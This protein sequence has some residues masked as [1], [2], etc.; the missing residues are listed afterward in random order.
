MNNNSRLKKVHISYKHDVAHKDAINA[1]LEGLKRNEIPVSYDEIDLRY[2]CDIDKYEKEIGESDRVIIFVTDDYLK[3]IECMFEMSQMF[4]NKNV[5][6]RIFPIVDLQKISRDGN[7]LA[8][9]KNYWQK[10]KEKKLNLAIPEYG[11]ST[12]LLTEAFKIS[13][14]LETLDDF[15]NFICRHYTGE[16]KKLIKDDAALL[17]DEL[18][19]TMA[20]VLIDNEV[21]NGTSKEEQTDCSREI[22]QNGEKSIYIENNQGNIT[23]N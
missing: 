19:K 1:I 23:I 16:Y 17:I 6:E 18:K 7:G 8:E 13:G 5:M 2:K 4:K 11:S 9:V 12:F 3:S 21:K 10:E 15:W 14:I 22:N 20:N